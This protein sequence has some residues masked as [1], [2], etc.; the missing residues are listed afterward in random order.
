MYLEY[1]L[2]MFSR[3]GFR[4]SDIPLGIDIETFSFGNEDQ[5]EDEDWVVLE[6]QLPTRADLAN[7]RTIM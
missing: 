7:L 5:A 6:S 1:S 2:E 3:I 4:L